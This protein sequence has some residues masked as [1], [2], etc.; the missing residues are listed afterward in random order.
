M[1]TIPTCLPKRG[2]SKKINWKENKLSF[3]CHSM[4]S[5]SELLELKCVSDFPKI[6]LTND[7]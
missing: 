3:V 5:H 4:T 2:L 6:I 1:I 7:C